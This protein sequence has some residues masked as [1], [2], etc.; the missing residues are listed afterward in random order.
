MPQ[1]VEAAARASIRNPEDTAYRHPDAMEDE[2]LAILGAWGRWRLSMGDREDAMQA[3]LHASRAWLLRDRPDQASFPLTAAAA[4]SGVWATVEERTALFDLLPQ[5]HS[6][7]RRIGSSTRWVD[8]ALARSSLW[9]ERHQ[10]PRRSFPCIASGDPDISDTRLARLLQLMNDP[11]APPADLPPWP[12]D[13]DYFDAWLLRIDEAVWRG[14]P[15]G[16]PSVTFPLLAPAASASL[17]RRC[18]RLVA[19]APLTGTME[20]LLWLAVHLL[21]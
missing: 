10:E 11:L 5:F 1:E 13:A 19:R 6:A 9:A 3:S 2:D 8:E 15:A 18:K 12:T 17:H 16:F 4:M 20:G 7:A 14:L 21:A